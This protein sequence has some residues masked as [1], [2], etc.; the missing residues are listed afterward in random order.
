MFT[1]GEYEKLGRLL[2]NLHICMDLKFALMDADSREVYTAAY[3]TPFCRLI[4]E[5]PGGYERCRRCDAE[6]LK[7][8]GES[9]GMVIYRCHAGLIE[10]AMPVRVGGELTCSIMFGQ[11]L[12]DTPAQQQWNE[13]MRRCEWYG[14]M[15]ELQRA[16]RLLRRMSQRQIRALGEI[17]NACVSEVRLAGLLASAGRSDA[18]RLQDYIAAHYAEPL[19]VEGICEALSI[20]KSKLYSICRAET[21]R[22]VGELICQRRMDAARTLLATTDDSVRRI[23]ETVGYPDFNYFAKVFRRTCGMTPSEYRSRASR[24]NV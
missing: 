12:D 4:S 11:V 17:V 10:A 22:T 7:R 21:G 16:F 18:G 9:G 20:S 23:A 5:A 8:M 24:E 3:K 19:S 14:D 6:A 2:D 1:P 15:D 13:T